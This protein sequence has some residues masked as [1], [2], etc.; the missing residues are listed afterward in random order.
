M[1]TQKHLELLRDL[2][3]E[4]EYRCTQIVDACYCDTRA[5]HC[6][7]WSDREVYCCAEHVE[8]VKRH[9]ASDNTHDRTNNPRVSPVST[10]PLVARLDEAIAELENVCA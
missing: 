9:A 1:D 10:H 4:I 3:A 2:L 8:L 5:T 6:V 7:T